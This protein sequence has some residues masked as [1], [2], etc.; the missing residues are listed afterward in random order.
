LL[1]NAIGWAVF[2]RPQ[3]E[4]ES[5]MPVLLFSLLSV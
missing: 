4:H 3:P 5:M 2:G 1:I